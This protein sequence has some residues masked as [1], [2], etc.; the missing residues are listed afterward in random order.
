MNETTTPSQRMYDNLASGYRDYSLY[1]GAY[2]N[3]VDSV[4]KRHLKPDYSIIDFGS[5]DGVRINNIAKNITSK[6]CL[7]ENSNNMLAK[8]KEQYPHALVSNQDFA[9]VNFQTNGK[10]DIATCLWNVLGHLGNKEQVLS[11]LKNIR[12]SIKPNGIVILDVNNRHNIAQYKWKAIR[13]IIKDFFIYKFENGDIKFNIS[14]NDK[15]IPSCVHIFDK[16]EIENLIN[17]AGFEI[18]S[19]IYINYANGNIKKSALFGQLCYILSIKE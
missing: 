1:R 16:Y 11:G 14:V 3:T 5:G 12:K 18:K 8:I 13:N 2:L 4:V 7:V 10:Y 9:D 19:K 17:M 6:L 15:Q